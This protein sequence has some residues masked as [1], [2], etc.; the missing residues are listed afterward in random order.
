MKISKILHRTLLGIAGIALFY[1]L[2][3]CLPSV[4]QVW[5]FPFHFLV[6]LPLAILTGIGFFRLQ[7]SNRKTAFGLAGTTLLGFLG[8]YIFVLG[9]MFAAFPHVIDSSYLSRA[10]ADLM[11]PFFCGSGFILVLVSIVV[12]KTI[13]SRIHRSEEAN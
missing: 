12:S 13:S 4:S 5:R 6:S 7:T 8:R 10:E 1:L 3:M 9:C 2:L 11:M